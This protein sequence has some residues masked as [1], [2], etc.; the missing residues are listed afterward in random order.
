VDWV[1]SDSGF[2]KGSLCVAP[3]PLA[4]G[5]AIDEAAEA[6]IG[7]LQEV[8]GAIRNIRGEMFVP[9]EMK[10]EALIEHDS[11]ACRAALAAQE[12]AIRALASVSALKVGEKLEHPKFASTYV[13][14]GT[15]ILVVLPTELVEKEQERLRKELEFAQKG[16]AACRGK[17]GNEGFV[18]KAPPNVV[19][20]E[21]AKLAK[22]EADVE[23]MRQK[24]ASMGG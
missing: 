24:L 4:G 8:I 9:G 19:E 5:F 1:G 3:W 14:G 18:A 11:A 12:G 6:E 22:L 21:R 2:A 15:T 7:L 10:V 20:Q 16:L 17:L 23:A 13:S